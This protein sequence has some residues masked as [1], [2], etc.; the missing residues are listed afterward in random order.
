[1]KLFLAIL[2]V[3]FS[4]IVKA[5]TIV[6]TLNNKIVNVK[7]STNYSFIVSGHFYGNKNNLTGYPTNTLLANLDWVNNSKT[8]ML[9]CLGDLF[10][11]VKNDIP[12]YKTSLFNKLNI[13]LFNAVGNHDISSDIYQTNF[14]ATFYSFKINNDIHLFLD[15]ELNDG[16][17]KNKQIELLKSVKNQAKSN[18]DNVFIYSHRTIWARNYPQLNNLFTSN[19]QSKFGNNFKSD[20]LPIIEQINKTTKVTWLSGSL[21]EAPSS[22]FNFKSKSGINYVATAIRGLKRDAVLIINSNKGKL[23]FG[24]KSFTNQKL[25]KFET[26]NTQYWNSNIGK[27]QPFNFRLLP[28]Y[29]KQVVFG[30]HFWFGI[31]T[32]IIL[33]FIYKKI[34]K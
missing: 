9:I 22:V 27:A 23:S 34:K 30:Y 20:I 2:I 8:V 15:T 33:V 18:I 4:F 17:I 29:V 14:G 1:M 25:N 24:L 32:G 12:K 10:M 13:P 31:L 28:L 3:G 7:N 21:G 11:D 6:S 26:Y 5:D 16:S 19:T